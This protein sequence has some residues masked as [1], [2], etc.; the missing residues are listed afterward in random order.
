MD[1]LLEEMDRHAKMVDIS[2]KENCISEFSNEF[3]YAM[4][5]KEMRVG[6]KAIIW[7]LHSLF[8]KHS[9]YRYYF[10]PSEK[11]RLPI[12]IPRLLKRLIDINTCQTEK[13]LDEVEEIYVFLRK[14][15]SDPQLELAGMDLVATYQQ[16]TAIRAKFNYRKLPA[17]VL[18]DKIGFQVN[19]IE[20]TE[21]RSSGYRAK[22]DGDGYRWESQC[23]IETLFF[24]I[25]AKADPIAIGVFR[26]KLIEFRPEVYKTIGGK[27]VNTTNYN[28]YFNFSQYSTK[29]KKKDNSESLV[30]SVIDPYYDKW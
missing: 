5:R 26:E 4:A 19:G 9:T 6:D 16:I 7:Y 20:I 13:E 28:Q 14:D 10:N 17:Q 27:K 30:I 1:K 22:A 29:G 2:K 25:S 3:S 12:L 18:L 23:D 24:S 8:R 11:E 15:F 21:K